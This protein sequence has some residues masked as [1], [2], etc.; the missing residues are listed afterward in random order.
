MYNVVMLKKHKAQA[1][2]E[3]VYIDELVP[4]DHLLRKITKVIDFE[5]IRDK[6]EHLYC[7]DN[8]RPPVDP[9]VLF[10]MLFIGYL[11]GI[12]SERQLMRD[13][14]V[15]VAYRWFIGYELDEKLPDHSTL[16]KTL[17]RFGDDVFND[18]KT[19]VKEVVVI[20]C[21]TQP[22][23]HLIVL[24]KV[25]ITVEHKTFGFDKAEVGHHV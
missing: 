6:V 15:N 2:M 11:F 23:Q 25:G 18:L 14:E 21:K 5:F 13:I 1:E 22:A 19:E 16:S 9:V 12:R 8:G 20:I 10:K 17:D 7:A 24:S 3:F 4:K